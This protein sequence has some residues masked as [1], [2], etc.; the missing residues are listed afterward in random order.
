MQFLEEE[1]PVLQEKSIIGKTV[2]NLAHFGVEPLINHASSF[3]GTQLHEVIWKN[4]QAAVLQ[5]AS[6]TKHLR[7]SELLPFCR[8]LWLVLVRAVDPD[9][10]WSA[11][12]WIKFSQVP[13]FLTFEQY[14]M[15]FTT[16]ENSSYGYFLP[17]RLSWIRIRIQ[18]KAGS[19]SAKMNKDPQ[20]WFW[21]TK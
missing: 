13:L 16:K 10:H 20:P 9:L 11:N 14:F 17:T 3:T 1:R 7:S 18:K 6:A 19:G 5:L 15:H 21:V 4:K 2:W 8:G 12:F